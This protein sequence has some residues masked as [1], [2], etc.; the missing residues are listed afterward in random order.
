M[1]QNLHP[2]IPFTSTVLHPTYPLLSYLH[3][4]HFLLPSPLSNLLAAPFLQLYLFFLFPSLY[5]NLF[6]APIPPCSFEPFLCSSSLLM[7]M[8]LLPLGAGLGEKLLLILGFNIDSF[9]F[10]PISLVMSRSL[11]RSEGPD[12]DSSRRSSPSSS[13]SEN[14]SSLATR[15][16]C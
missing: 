1:I 15:L 12:K 5:F 13:E 9:S 11:L 14:S 7:P 10:S 16:S 8:A 3:F 4:N 6:P 2:Q